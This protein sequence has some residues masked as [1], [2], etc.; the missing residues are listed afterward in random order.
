MMRWVC[1]P[2]HPAPW[3]LG[4]RPAGFGLVELLIALALGLVLVLGVVQVFLASKQTFMVQ[5]SAA[6]LQEDARYLLGRLSREL[7]M[8][9]MYGCLDL[10]RLPASIRATVPAALETPLIYSSDSGLDTLTLITAVPNSESFIV[11]TTRRPGDYGARWLIVSNCRDTADLRI[12]EAADLVVRPGDLVI[13]LRQVDYRVNAHALQ[14]RNNGV[15]NYQTLLDG[16]ASLSLS[17][18]LAAT[19]G[20]RQVSGAYVN[21]VAAHQGEL[22][23]S[24]KLELQLSDT[25]ASPEQG[26]VLAQNFKQ[27]VALR[28][29]IE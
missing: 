7:R 5:R 27:V 3:R 13:P 2:L 22:I 24:V 1:H 17:F 20:Q 19:A 16:V 6:I 10:A 26:R 25:P 14:I 18:G 11:S 23:R 29:R 8:L 28:N 21:E 4:I 12:S 9:N 15:G